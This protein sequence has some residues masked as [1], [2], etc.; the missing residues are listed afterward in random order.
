MDNYRYVFKSGKKLKTG[1][2]TGSCAAAASKAAVVM[3][4]SGEPVQQVE[5]ETPKGWGLKLDVHEPVIQ[6]G[7]A[8]CYVIKDAGD[9]PDITDGIHL[10]AAARK[11]EGQGVTI[12]AS[13]GIGVVTKP[14]LSVKSGMPAINPVP[15]QM[16]H[17]EVGAVLPEGCGVEIELFIPNGEELARRTYNPKLGI[18]GGLSILGTSGIVEPM[19]EDAIKDTIA[20]ELSC[21][22]EAGMNTI[23]LVPG[24]YGEDFCKNRLSIKEEQIVKVSNYLGFALEKCAE[25]G[26]AKVLIAGHLGK[27]VKPAGGIFYTHSRISDTRMEI[28]AAHL[29]VMGMTQPHLKEVMS[30]RTTEEAMTVIEGCGF[31]TVYKIIADKCAERCSGYIFDAFEVGVVLFSMAALLALGGEAEKVLEDFNRV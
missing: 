12:K 29:G 14:G 8:C 21:R 5:I 2:T 23:A 30:C 17:K 7:M 20:L 27:L 3:L 6:E 13:K 26:F 22:K 4:F 24:N 18:I 9:D 28:L 25:L 19:S 16:I 10:H 31:E 15:M 11:S 1:Y